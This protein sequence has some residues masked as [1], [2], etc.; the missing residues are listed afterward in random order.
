MIEVDS[1]VLWVKD[2]GPEG[3][4]FTSPVTRRTPDWD[5]SCDRQSP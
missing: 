2:F 4:P 5:E 1:N 3:V